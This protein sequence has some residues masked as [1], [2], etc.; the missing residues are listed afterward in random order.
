MKSVY[1]LVF[2]LVLAILG[3]L[4]SCSKKASDEAYKSCVEAGVHK[5]EQCYFWA[6]VE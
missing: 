2:V 1:F 4:A 3:G 5:N 6:Y